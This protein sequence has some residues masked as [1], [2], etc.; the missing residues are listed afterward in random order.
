ME[1]VAI[2]QYVRTERLPHIWCPGCGIGIVTGAFLRAVVDLGL[3]REKTIVVG[4]IVRHSR[5]SLS[6]RSPGRGSPGA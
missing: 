6:A 4:A 1:S 2:D 5:T 3:V